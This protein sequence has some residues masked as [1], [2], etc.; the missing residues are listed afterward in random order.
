MLII[1]KIATSP[2]IAILVSFIGFSS[3]SAEQS[4]STN[5]PISA[6]I[7]TDSAAKGGDV[8]ISSVFRIIC[9][10]K[11]SMGTGFL[12][13]SGN[14]ITAAHVVKSCPEPEVMLS[15]GAIASSR[16][17]ASDD[18]LDIAV[19]VPTFPIDA[20]ALTISSKSDFKVGHQVSTWGF[21]GGYNGLLPML[22]VGYLSGMQAVKIDKKIVTQWVINAAFNRRNSGGP[23]ILIETGEVIGIVSSKIAPISDEAVIAINALQN[24]TSGFIY[25]ETR[26][27]GTITKIT[28]GQV[29]AMVLE[30][31]RKQVQLVIGNAVKLEDMRAFLISQKIDP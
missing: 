3:S 20:S 30:E 18:D 31:L 29:V 2:A 15:T 14:I 8:A 25:T 7:D 23:L 4:A 16:V 21:P 27:D 10:A 5:V 19:I 17:V 28:E 11:N 9:R 1:K 12:H 13:K 26:P 22:S 24:T 6:P